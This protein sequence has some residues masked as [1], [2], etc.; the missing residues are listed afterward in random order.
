MSRDNILYFRYYEIHVDKHTNKYGTHFHHGLLAQL[1]L[2]SFQ[3]WSK[4][5]WEG[6]DF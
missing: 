1:W 3:I 6:L 2:K 4:Q 5:Y